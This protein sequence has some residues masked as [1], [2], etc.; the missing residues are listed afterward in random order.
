M[1]KRSEAAHFFEGDA[2]HIAQARPL[3]LRV[4]ET[5]V[6]KATSLFDNYI[7]LN[8]KMR[9]VKES[10]QTTSLTFFIIADE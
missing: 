7:K 8:L 9:K 2:S 4:K 6:P 10:N 1:G 3:G 5:E